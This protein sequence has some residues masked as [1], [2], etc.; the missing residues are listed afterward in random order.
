MS[1]TVKLTILFATLALFA[2]QAQAFPGG[3]ATQPTAAPAA[4]S[5]PV[6]LQ[7]TVTETMDSGG[8][9]YVCILKSGQKQWAAVPGTQVKVGDSV[10]VAP[11]AVMKNF[12]SKSLG[13]TFDEI[14]FS[15][16]L[17]KK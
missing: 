10:E 12:S 5:Q 7:G 4:A 9:T 1:K 11:G 8:Y 6:A 16:G 3:A 13:R 17:T 14:V 2:G 15:R